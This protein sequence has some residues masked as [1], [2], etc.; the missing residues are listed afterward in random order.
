MQISWPA[1]P[2][3]RI[4]NAAAAKEPMPPPTRYA[5]RLMLTPSSGITGTAGY[6]SH[7]WGVQTSGGRIFRLFA[8]ERSGLRL[9]HLPRGSADVFPDPAG[10][11][12]MYVF[13]NHR[14]H[15]CLGTDTDSNRCRVVLAKCG[16]K[17]VPSIDIGIRRRMPYSSVERA[18][19]HRLGVELTLNSHNGGWRWP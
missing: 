11:H 4:M 15:G 3:S 10:C 5:W 1:R 12:D 14:Q 6:L 16:S 17:R 19:P 18:P 7:R 13:H 2:P 8:T 9:G